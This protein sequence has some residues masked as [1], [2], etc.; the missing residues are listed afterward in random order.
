M[1]SCEARLLAKLITNVSTGVQTRAAMFVDM[2]VCM[3]SQKFM[4]LFERNRIAESSGLRHFVG[5]CV[6]QK[7]YISD[8]EKFKM[9]SH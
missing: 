2:Y 4:T 9:C 5:N 1:K 6:F 8:F 3:L 7:S